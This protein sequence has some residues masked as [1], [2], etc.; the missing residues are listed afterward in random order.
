MQQQ[1]PGVRL[2]G[3]VHETNVS[4]LHFESNNCIMSFQ[5]FFDRE[6]HA[7]SYK[8]APLPFKPSRLNG[9]SQRLV[10]SHYENNYGG[11]LRRLNAIERQLAGLDSASAPN[12]LVNGLGR[13]QLI[14]ANSVLLHEVYFECL[15]GDGELSSDLDAALARD[16]GSVARWCAGFVAMA[17]ALAGGSGWALLSWSPRL[18]RLVSQ[19][20]ADHT[21]CL[22]E[23]QVILALDMYEHAYH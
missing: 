16:F 23:G 8:A 4:S 20:A 21:H 11:A 9:L 7:M 3:I 2:I 22:A 12:F 19:W 14:A 1:E 17:K 13:E 18:G 15:G 6:S 10:A 5:P